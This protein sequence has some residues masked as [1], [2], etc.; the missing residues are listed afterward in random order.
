MTLSIVQDEA[1]DEVL[2]TNAFALLCGML[3][4]Q[5]APLDV[6][7]AGPAKILDRFGSLDPAVISEAPP[8]EFAELC[9]TEPAVHPYP[10]SMAVLVQALARFIVVNYD[11][12][13][14]AVWRTA[15][16]GEHLV[17]RLTLM[18]GFGKRMAQMFIALLG[19]QLDVRP[20]GWEKAAGPYAE[21]GGFRSVADVHDRASLDRV[22]NARSARRKGERQAG[23]GRQADRRSA[24]NTESK[25]RI[26]VNTEDSASSPGEAVDGSVDATAAGTADGRG[27]DDLGADEAGDSEEKRAARKAARRAARKAARREA[28]EGTGESA[29]LD[30]D[31]DAV[32]GQPAP[33]A[34]PD[35]DE[36]EGSG[37]K[38]TPE[39][40]A[41][42]KAKKAAK[43]AAR[44]AAA[45]KEP[46][47]EGERA[48]RRGGARTGR[49][50]R[51]RTAE[52]SS[53]A[54]SDGIEA[55]PTSSEGTGEGS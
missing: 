16:S 28:S 3:L 55:V 35:S 51:N 2:S 48:G 49:G 53:D 14:A 5:Q 24:H 46:E 47:T 22:L 32:G 31:T 50:T 8:D 25:G 21:V 30:D 29:G 33:D 34:E 44:R 10:E 52:S 26:H 45:G 23:D 27:G 4:L 43:R 39:Q 19:R 42:R 40:R 17:S 11:G 38:L 6:A 7:F 12:D 1:A 15:G 41:E 13:T 37:E 36:A 54:M 18:P 20:Q 9:A